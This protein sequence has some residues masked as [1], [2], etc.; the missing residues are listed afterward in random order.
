MNFESLCN[1]SSILAITISMLMIC[2]IM[3]MHILYTEHLLYIQ[4]RHI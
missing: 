3:F 1:E 4:E 2:Y